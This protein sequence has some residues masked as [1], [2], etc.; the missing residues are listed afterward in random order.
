MELNNIIKYF[1]EE[2][3]IEI[4]KKL[5]KDETEN[6]S[7]I[8][9]FNDIFDDYIIRYGIIEDNN[10]SFLYSILFTLDDDF[11]IYDFR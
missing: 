1:T 5:N 11:K 2:K 7:K 8:N 3:D 10:L 9:K 6:I 4:I